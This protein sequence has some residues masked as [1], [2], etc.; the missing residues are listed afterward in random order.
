MYGK[1][2]KVDGKQRRSEILTSE[3][4]KK[5]KVGQRNIKIQRNTEELV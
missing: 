2:E 3:N 4:R 1:V 5:K